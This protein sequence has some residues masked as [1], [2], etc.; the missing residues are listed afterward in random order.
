M[1]NSKTTPDFDNAGRK[2]L[3]VIH[4]LPEFLIQGNWRP[5]ARSCQM[6]MRP[7][8]NNL[9]SLN[10]DGKVYHLLNYTHMILGLG[11]WRPLA[12]S[13]QM[14]MRPKY[15]WVSL[16][17]DGKSLRLYIHT[18]SLKQ[19]FRCSDENLL[20]RLAFQVPH[21]YMMMSWCCKAPS[22]HVNTFSLSALRDWLL[23]S[24]INEYTMM[25][26]CC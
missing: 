16:S 22:T 23:K 3:A 2:M 7:E 1:E 13:S 20:L 15:G 18:H 12:R 10:F 19:P 24:R 11:N 8:A 14:H 21:E 26:C 25:S 4:S 17:L 6:Q 5:L 9:V